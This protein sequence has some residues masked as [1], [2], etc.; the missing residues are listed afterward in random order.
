[1][2][3]FFVRSLAPAGKSQQDAGGP[4]GVQNS[5]AHPPDQAMLE[6][7]QPNAIL[8]VVLTLVLAVRALDDSAVA[9]GVAL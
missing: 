6:Q 8:I 7:G 2:C 1:V 4:R 9:I 5:D 3:H